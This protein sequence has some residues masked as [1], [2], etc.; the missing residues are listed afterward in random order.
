MAVN[1]NYHRIIPV[2]NY[3]IAG[4][5]TW[6]SDM[7]EKGFFLTDLGAYL[8]HF[9]KTEPKTV[10]YRLEP[11][12]KNEQRPNPELYEIYKENGWRYITTRSKMF[13]VFMA[14]DAT[15]PEIHT[16]P[17]IQ[18]GTLKKIVR[19]LVIS[20]TVAVAFV[21]L[22]V[23]FSVSV[24]WPGG[25][26]VR[27]VLLDFNYNLYVV[28]PIYILVSI[29]AF[30]SAARL[31]KLRRRLHKGLPFE[32]RRKY[33]RGIVL[34]I[35][36]L[37]ATFACVFALVVSLI[38]YAATGVG[39]HKPLSEIRRDV[40]VLSLAEIDP[41]YVHGSYGSFNRG[42]TPLVPVQYTIFQRKEANDPYQIV[43]QTNYYKAAFPCLTKHVYNEQNRFFIEFLEHNADYEPLA[44]PLFDEA[45][46]CSSD[47]AQTIIA[48]RNKTV[49][50]VRYYGDEYLPDKLD[51]IADTFL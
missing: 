43:L 17:V 38:V 24:F 5:E 18:S 44:T 10:R 28:F 33:K 3:D 29:G 4:M 21:P 23:I 14:E 41:G 19:Q 48:Y 36:E 2:T 16:D 15:A 42:Y 27:P 30:I 37:C 49:I 9:R 8:G 11:A 25:D 34:R 6:L 47:L 35:I 32:H 45:V 39:N 7:A 31:I 20:L 1:K 26:W 46:Y 50:V 40:P 51:L 13:H 12:G 22:F